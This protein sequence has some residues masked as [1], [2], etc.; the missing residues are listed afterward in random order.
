MRLTGARIAHLPVEI[1]IGTCIIIR[2]FVMLETRPNFFFQFIWYTNRNLLAGATK[3][4]LVFWNMLGYSIKGEN[5]VFNAYLLTIL[6][7]CFDVGFWNLIKLARVQELWVLRILY[8]FQ[9][10]ACKNYHRTRNDLNFLL[11]M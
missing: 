2:I 4:Q 11:Y 10:K 3:F 8:T 7:I 9:N 5:C 6:Y 1:R